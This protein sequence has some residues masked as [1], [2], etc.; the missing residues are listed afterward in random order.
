[1]ILSTALDPRYKVELFPKE[2]AENAKK[3]LI[4][5]VQEILQKG[6]EI[7]FQPTTSK[8][9]TSYEELLSELMQGDATEEI[10][11]VEFVTDP[12]NKANVVCF[13]IF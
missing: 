6:T 12:V 3:W 1:M 10:E 8:P 9:R 7:S 13:L 4:D 2:V 11:K 5:E